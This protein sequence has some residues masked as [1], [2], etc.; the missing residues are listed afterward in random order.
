MRQ[1]VVS[2]VLA[3]VTSLFL[4]G[5]STLA[6]QADPDPERF[7][8]QFTSFSAWDAQN[9]VPEDAVLFVGS[10]SIRFWP[11]AERFPGVP[12]INRGFGGSHISDVNHFIDES[13]L[14]YAPRVIVFY[15]GDNDIGSGKS[16]DQVLED[17][18]EFVQT[19]LDVY[20][21]TQIIY[22]AIKPS[23]ARWD[24][25]P[26]MKEF[27]GSVQSYSA[28]RPNLHY[29]DIAAPMLGADGTPRPE[30]FVRDGLHMTPA[31]YDI[32]DQVINASLARIH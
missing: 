7:S 21:E 5:T 15:A 20:P 14:Q 26:Q 6:A 28:A 22:I 24:L 23:L 4:G 18:D 19:V 2:P 3:V 11:S 9:S 29:A 17:Y 1:L 25:W 13:V 31:G 30:L 27:N 8:E 10:S 12:V 32:W 16:N